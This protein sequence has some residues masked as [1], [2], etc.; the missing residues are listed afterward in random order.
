MSEQ[1]PPFLYSWHEWCYAAGQPGEDENSIELLAMKFLETQHAL[2]KE[3]CGR[4]FLRSH[5]DGICC[6]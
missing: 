3:E 2:Y 5:C 4:L 6:R 1:V